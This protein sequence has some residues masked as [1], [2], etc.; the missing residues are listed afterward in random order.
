MRADAK[1]A[2]IDNKDV[3]RA[4]RRWA[5]IYDLTFG[6]LVEV[7]IKHATTSVNRYD[8]RVLEVGVGTGLSLPYYKASLKV[9]GIDLSAEMLAKARERVERGRLNNI[10]QLR[11]MDATRLAFAD[12]SFDVAAAMYVMTVVPDPT[13]VMHELARVTKIGGQ[14][15]IVNHFSVE[16]GLRGMIEK[17]LARFSDV[18]GWRPEFPIRALMVSDRL[19][20]EELRPLRPMGLFTLLRLRRVF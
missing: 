16:G 14:V 17:N 13:A 4:Y 18:L 1:L 2:E 19:K 6:K 15:V 3:V 10:E 7:G 12:Q 20:L 9:T 8:G 5:P 11:E